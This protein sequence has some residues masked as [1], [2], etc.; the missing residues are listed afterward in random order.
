MRVKNTTNSTNLIIQRGAVLLITQVHTVMGV[1]TPLEQRQA[2]SPVTHHVA[3]VTSVA[4][5]A[6]ISLML[7]CVVVCLSH[8]VWDCQ[9]GIYTGTLTK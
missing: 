1:I 5:S 3:N 8:P 9:P 7:K 4:R 6:S 2:G